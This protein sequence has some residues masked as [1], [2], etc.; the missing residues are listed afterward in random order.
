[1]T[2]HTRFSLVAAV[3]VFG[4]G[5]ALADDLVFPAIRGWQ[6]RGQGVGV[7][8]AQA[9]PPATVSV[10][11]LHWAAIEGDAAEIRR[12]LAA[13]ANINAT[14]T[15]WGGERPL[16]WAAFSGSRQA[17]RALLDAGAPIE[18]RD[19]QG[20]TALHEVLNANDPKYVAMIEL[21]MKGADPHAVTDYGMSVLH[22]AVAA[23]ANA[24]AAIVIL[25]RFGADPNV[26]ST[27]DSGG[28]TPLHLAAFAPG[29]LGSKAIDLNVLE[30]LDA[31]DVDPLGRE[32]D[33]NAP[34]DFGLTPLHVAVLH[35]GEDNLLVVGWLLDHG[36]NPDAEDDDG[37]TA[38]DL[39]R[40]IHGPFSQVVSLLQAVQN[41]DVPPPPSAP[42][43]F[44]PQAIEIA[45]GASG[46][47][48]TLMTTEAGGFTLDGESVTSGATYSATIGDYTL[49]FSG[50]HWTATFAPESVEVV[51]GTSGDTVS[52]TQ[53][54]DGSYLADG[55]PFNSGSLVTT[56][57]GNEYR[58]TLDASGWSWEFVP[59]PAV[60]MQLGTSGITVSITQ[61]E[62]GSYLVDGNPLPED[63]IVT[64]SNG[65]RYR[66]TLDNIGW[67]WEFVP[68]PTVSVQL[69]TSGDTVSITQQED[70]SYLVD[71]N[72]LPGN[73]IVTASNGNRYRLTFGDDGVWTA[74]IV[75]P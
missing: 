42:P 37:A 48:I 20:E 53:Q 71:G 64:A 74:V 10:S 40:E 39:A 52:I 73:R 31:T 2:K 67:W 43:P 13:G 24:A 57:N 70:G 34:N 44:Q 12:L 62:D 14:E 35:P 5:V 29:V 6:S 8:Q 60:S 1:M 58:L 23:Q 33:V 16:H 68:P 26:R 63:R 65:N 30:A 45:L 18:V 66:L 17:V 59:P 11:D 38:L 61:Q 4:P 9:T 36:A 72:P 25:R 49:T 3:G 55:Q 28:M 51:L 21:L 47:S 50:G 15:L 19:D 56:V 75:A 7:L 54:E 32:L 22:Y 46:Q 27:G 41:T 69:G